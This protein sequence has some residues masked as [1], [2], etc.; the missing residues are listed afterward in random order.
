[1]IVRFLYFSNHLKLPLHRLKL[2]SSFH[3][4]VIL[5]RHIFFLIRNLLCCRK[6]L[7]TQKFKSEKIKNFELPRVV[8]QSRLNQ[9][10]SRNP[11]KLIFKINFKIKVNS[12]F[13]SK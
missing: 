4:Q 5:S 7:K 11:K 2:Y 10:E 8:A 9:N 12:M 3:L 1:M 6:F 13:K